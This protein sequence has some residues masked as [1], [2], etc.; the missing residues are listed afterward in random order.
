MTGLEPVISSDG[1]L[2]W[3]TLAEADPQAELVFL[4]LME[5]GCAAFAAVPEAGSTTHAYPRLWRALAGVDVGQLAIYGGARAVVD[6]HARHR[7]CAR[8]GGAT[9]LAK[10]GWQRNCSACNAEHYPRVDPATITAAIPAT[11]QTLLTPWLKAR[12]SSN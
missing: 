1:D 4:G 7:F 8:C 12:R 2:E 6:W 3:G 11:H 9:V 5:D 10:G